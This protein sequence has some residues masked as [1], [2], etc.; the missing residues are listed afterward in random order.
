M[1]QPILYLASRSPRRR[2]LLAQIGIHAVVLGIIDVD[3]T[4]RSEET[5]ED[6]VRRI[7]IAKAQGIFDRLPGR[8]KGLVLGADTAVV[9]EDAILGKPRQR[10]QAVA[11]LMRLAGRTHRVLTGVAL[12]D[13][14]VQYRLSES[15]VSFRPITNEE[16][17]AYWDSGEPLDKAGGYAIQGLGALFVDHLEGSYSGVMGLPLFETGELLTGAGIRVLGR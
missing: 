13:G 6:Y 14:S 1:D 15:C 7:A 4:V 10:E 16:I 8:S 3:E 17:N 9:V 5:A 11:M 12:I 2:A